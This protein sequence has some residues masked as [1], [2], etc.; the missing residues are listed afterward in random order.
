[1]REPVCA[2]WLKSEAHLSGCSSLSVV[3]VLTLCCQESH[4]V[5]WT[6]RNTLGSTT[7]SRP[8]YLLNI[9]TWK[10]SCVVAGINWLSKAHYSYLLPTPYSVTSESCCQPKANHTVGVKPA[11][12]SNAMHLGF[13]VL[14][15]APGASYSAFMR[16][17]H[18]LDALA[19]S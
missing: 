15:W 6:I 2:S 14:P 16:S 7:A 5:Y 3:M 18:C 17:Y 4:F 1:M 9:F 13:P 11:K 19:A 8:Q 10:Q 12:A